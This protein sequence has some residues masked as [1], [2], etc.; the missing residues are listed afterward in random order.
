MC[1]GLLSGCVPL[2]NNYGDNLRESQSSSGNLQGQPESG[3]QIPPPITLA[4]RT[5]G[6]TSPGPHSNL[7]Q[8]WQLLTQGTD[9][10]A[11]PHALPVPH[12]LPLKDAD[13][14]PTQEP[15][16]QVSRVAGLAAGGLILHSPRVDLEDQ[17]GGS[18]ELKEGA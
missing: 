5:L 14:K 13:P 15:R 11:D 4:V 12:Y 1:T 10:Q 3:F 17:G 7:T 9:S 18:E 6:L 2:V 8:T 16:P